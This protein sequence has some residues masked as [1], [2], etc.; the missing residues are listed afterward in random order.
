MARTSIAAA[1]ADAETPED[2]GLGTARMEGGTENES[3][4][5]DQRD[6]GRILK[7]TVIRDQPTL[8]SSGEYKPSV[9]RS[10]SGNIVTD[11]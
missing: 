9:Y 1:A 3:T 4:P 11:R 2:A 10:V 8:G 5:Q 6:P 7:D